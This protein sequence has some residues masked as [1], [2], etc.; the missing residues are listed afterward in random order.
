MHPAT[1][2]EPSKLLTRN[3]RTKING[4]TANA[5]ETLSKEFSP[6]RLLNHKWTGSRG[7]HL[8]EK[9]SSPGNKEK[10]VLAIACQTFK[11]VGSPIL[12]LYK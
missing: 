7:H 8:L 4:L 9:T 11:R 6:P 1:A 3:M 12:V 5:S 10:T 2:P